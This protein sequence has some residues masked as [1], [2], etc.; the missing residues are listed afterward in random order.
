MHIFFITATAEVNCKLDDGTNDTDPYDNTCCVNITLNITLV[1]QCIRID[2]YNHATIGRQYQTW[3]MHHGST[4]IYHTIPLIMLVMNHRAA[5]YTI[6]LIMLV[7][8][9]RAAIYHAITL[10]IL[11]TQL[12]SNGDYLIIT[13]IASQ[14]HQQTIMVPECN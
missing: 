5:I 10:I 12:K 8:N 3:S 7:M 1:R 4:A 11:T 13:S 2:Y 9:C 14:L 6:P